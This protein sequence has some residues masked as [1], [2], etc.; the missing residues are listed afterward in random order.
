MRRF[1]GKVIVVTGGSRGIG[2]AIA[3]AC[4]AEGAQLVLA[5]RERRTLAQAATQLPARPLAIAADVTRPA[6]VARL[7]RRVRQ[8][9]GR[10][11]VLIASA[12]A[13]TFRP[14]I[15]TSLADWRRN[16]ESNLTSLYLTTRAALPLLERSR[17]PHIVNILSVSSKQAFANCSAYCASKFGALGFTRVIAEELRPK[18]IRVT[19]V[20]PGSTNTRMTREFGFP[21]N[22]A[23]LI[24]PEDVAAAVLAALLQPARTTLDEVH[25]APSRGAL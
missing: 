10:V 15:R 11:D 6:Q 4:A 13:F 2:L 21:V 3:K 9:F 8:E 7:F 23:T 22:R 5:A 14:F 16:I 1:D 19:A 17:S 20:L 12:G 25:L 18:G 24:Q